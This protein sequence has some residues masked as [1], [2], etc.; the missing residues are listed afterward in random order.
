MYPQN[1]PKWSVSTQQQL[2][3]LH[4]A[5][6][7]YG[8]RIQRRGFY[9]EEPPGP[10]S[11]SDFSHRPPSAQ[12][13]CLLEQPPPFLLREGEGDEANAKAS[14]SEH[15]AKKAKATVTIPIKLVT[16]QE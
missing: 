13:L 8:S 6:Q 4:K 11:L 1:L 15:T 16:I 12:E 7:A 3:S 9:N 10:T 5:D 14:E 2:I